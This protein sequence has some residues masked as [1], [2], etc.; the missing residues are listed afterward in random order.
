M[1]KSTSGLPESF[2][3]NV[4]AQ[5]L[6][7]TEPLQIPGYLDEDPALL[8]IKMQQQLR[9]AKEAELR[10]KEAEN[11]VGETTQIVSQK[12][13]EPQTRATSYQNVLPTPQSISLERD[14][15]P[16]LTQRLGVSAKATVKDA[17]PP[18]IRRRLQVNL[19]A[20]SE[21]MV[22]ELLDILSNQ[23]SEHR[24]KI[25]ELFQASS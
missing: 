19:D 8:M 6:T 14:T 13:A 16:V 18:E 22:G 10:E 15:S 4:S 1:A 20:D 9:A 11:R 21:R 2:K 7:G 12:M 23:S 25:S 5:E 17:Q 3:L 24:I